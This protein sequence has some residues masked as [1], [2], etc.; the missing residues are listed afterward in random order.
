MPDKIVQ[1][2]AVSIVAVLLLML[3]FLPGG[4]SLASKKEF[5]FD[6]VKNEGYVA[7]IVNEYEST[8]K[9]DDENDTVNKCDCNGSKEI[10][11]GDGH[12]TPCPCT[13]DPEGCKCSKKQ[14]DVITG[15]EII[16]YIEDSKQEIKVMVDEVSDIRDEVVKTADLVKDLVL[17]EPIENFDKKAKLIDTDYWPIGKEKNLAVD[18]KQIV[19]FTADWCSPCRSFKANELPK[20]KNVGWKVGD[21]V[22]SHIRTV[23][24]DKDRATY[25]KWASQAGVRS[26]PL[27]VLVKNGKFAGYKSGYSSATTIAE[28][29]NAN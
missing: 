3:S 8:I 13:G 22:S 25:S 9:P 19:M 14:I 26:I 27:F 28:W 17:S 6:H 1:F 5:K 10:I 20:L 21:S 11:H 4:Q 15:E 12:K 29:Y 18:G 16:G 2:K 24:V 23:D 7:F